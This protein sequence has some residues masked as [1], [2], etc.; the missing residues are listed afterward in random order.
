[1]SGQNSKQFDTE[2][3]IIGAG[4]SGIM[5]YLRAVLNRDHTVLFQGDSETRRKGR[6]TWVHAVDNIPGMHNMK[7]PITGTA[8]STLKWIHEQPEL[9]DFG[10]PIKGK[11]TQVQR[12]EEGFMLHYHEKK[13]DKTLIAKYVILATGIMDVQPEINGS[14]KPLLPF[15]NKG[16]ALYCLRCD[17][18]RTLG[19]QLSI[20]GQPNKTVQIAALMH[21]RYGHEKIQLLAHGHGEELSEDNARLMRAYGMH[22][23]RPPILAV[24]G[25]PKEGLEGFLLADGTE[26]KCTQ[27]IVALGSI[28]YNELFKV[29]GGDLEDDGRIKTDAKYETSIPGFFA[30]GDLV[31]G[32]KMQLYTAW[33]EAVIAVE[34]INRRKRLAARELCLKSLN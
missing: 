10:T 16:H 32:T 21:E 3:A 4:G 31:A 2:I 15:A 23:Y 18:H 1:M 13:A 24:H 34:E 29:L 33:E 28:I 17:G 19:H 12:L 27:V 22:L 5:A 8:T 11:V 7:N 20:L 9:S 14:I 6:A 30:I 26:I 25:D